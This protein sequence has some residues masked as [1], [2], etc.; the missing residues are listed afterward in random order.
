MVERKAG[1]NREARNVSELGRGAR[2][3]LR[4]VALRCV[5]GLVSGPKRV[6]GC[7]QEGK[8]GCGGP[9]LG[10]AWL[11]GARTGVVGRAGLVSGGLGVGGGG[12][13]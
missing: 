5:S 6:S 4:L 7:L 1:R 3:A 8:R 11:D 9:R 10:L 12:R 13:A 2:L